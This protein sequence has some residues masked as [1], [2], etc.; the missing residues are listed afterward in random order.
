MFG[1]C[2]GNQVN[3]IVFVCINIKLIYLFLDVN[4]GS[5]TQAQT[6]RSALKQV[7]KLN[8]VPDHVKNYR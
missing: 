1:F 8:F 3:K 2:T 4:W 7:H 6:Y 5:S